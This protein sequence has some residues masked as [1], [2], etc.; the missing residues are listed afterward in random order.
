MIVAPLVRGLLGLE[1]EEGGTHLRFAPRLPADWNN[2]E[3]RNVAVGAARCDLKV[4]RTPG[5]LRVSV[6]SRSA[7]PKISDTQ[8]RRSLN[9]ILA[10]SFPLD[11]RVRSV[12]IEGRKALFYVRRRG[13]VQEIETNFSASAP[14]TEVIFNY[15]EGTD[16]YAAQQAPMT[17]AHSYGLRILHS[18][19][20]QDA[21]HLSLEGVGGRTY[22]LRVK[23]PRR[24]GESSGVTLKQE[25]NADAQLSF[26]FDAAPGEYVRRE[27]S[28]P[29]GARR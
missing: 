18:R 17:G 29:L 4:E 6:E 11:A 27:L 3:V 19:A 23:T 14:R 21:L 13:D 24:L 28:I 16:V 2:L 20:E 5:R 7:D 8:A 25:A 12:T 15:D 1:A 10:P 26:T 9:L 22:V